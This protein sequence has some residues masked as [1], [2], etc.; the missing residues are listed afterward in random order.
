MMSKLPSIG[1]IGAGKVGIVLAQL[2][3]KAG[4][5]VY[6]AGSGSAQKIALTISVLVPGA[7]AL[8]SKEVARKAKIIIL[9]IPLGRY[10]ELPKAELEGKLV[11]DAMNYWWEVDGERPDLT[12]LNVSSSELVQRFLSG[13][14]VVKA[15][16]HIG[17]HDLY[18]ETKPEGSPDR[19][20]IA[21]AGK[22]EEAN[23]VATLVND[24]GF[25]PVC[26]GALKEGMKLQP[27]SPIFGA[28]VDANTLKSTLDAL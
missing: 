25:D 19:K 28:H 27:G 9:A 13:S 16:N 23:K 21:I 12:D 10:K 24:L 6:I 11:I 1:I 3:T 22:A 8:T 15:F 20:A 14:K 26:I 4:Y 7:I 2:A 5:E 17:Y 18:D